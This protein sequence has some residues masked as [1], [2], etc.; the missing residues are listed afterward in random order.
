M[1]R[2]SWFAAF[3]VACLA[4]AFGGSAARAQGPLLSGAGPINRSMGGASTAAPLDPT[5]A[6]YWNPAGISG[7]SSSE[8]ALGLELFYP[9]STLSS[10]IPRGALGPGAPPVP[11]AGR[12]RDEVGVFALPSGGF[13]YR[14]EESD[15][16]F[17][18]GL[19]P[20][21]GF[22]V[23]YPGDATN[24]VLSAPPN[25]LGRISSIYQVFQITPTVAYQVTDRL[26]IGV[27]PIIDIARLELTP[28]LFVSPDDANGDGSPSYPAATGTRNAWGGGF[29][30]GV[31][32]TMSD[33]WRF[34]ASFRSPQ[35]FEPFRYKTLDES[36]RARSARFLFESPLIVSVGAAYTGFERVT[37][38]T[39][40]RYI[41]F[42]DTSG[43]RTAAFA[44]TGAVTGLGWR[45][46]FSAALGVQYQL[47]CDCSVRVGY[48]YNTDLIPA[49]GATFNV[50]SP[51]TYQHQLAVGVSYRLTPACTLSACYYHIFEGSVS[52]PFATPMGLI[53]GGRVTTGTVVDSLM[54]GASVR[55]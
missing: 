18:L 32:Y 31:Y 1:R 21:S 51:L 41:N 30:A 2:P 44:P 36:G 22:G 19:F 42:H 49:R 43:Q 7:L 39:D 40:L 9:R 4:L 11:L 47:T 12:T 53:P 45:D 8:L 48:T 55:F 15:W 27:A 13:V 29:Q 52:G 33:A 6:L 28:G 14:P 54:V 23:N 26:S 10:S 5:G 38:A 34:G 16:T 25:G 35:W 3:P 24:P 50:T 37:I 46:V 17:G 20:A